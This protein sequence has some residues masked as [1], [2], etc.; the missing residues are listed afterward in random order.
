M[1]GPFDGK[2]G[3]SAISLMMRN[4]AKY[5][6]ESPGF[7][8]K[9]LLVEPGK[10]VSLS[11]DFDTK[12]IGDFKAKEEA[13]EELKK[14]VERLGVEQ[15]VLYAGDTYA[16]LVVLQALDAAGKDGTIK[17]VMTGVNPQGCD[18]HSFKA[19]SQE[20]LDHDYLWRAAMR[21]P[22]RGRIG[23]FNR[24]YYEEV[25]VARVHP[26]LL[27]QQH[28]PP[29]GKRESIWKRRYEEINS[30]ERYLVN[31]GIVVLKFFLN[32]SKSEQKSRFLKRI[33]EKEKNWK[34]SA[35][36][37]HERRF[38]DDYIEAFEEVF[39]R[40]ST[41]WAPW[42]IIPADHKWFT[43]LCVSEII[44]ATLRSLGLKYPTIGDQELV[45]LQKAKEELLD[46]K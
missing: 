5:L 14:S 21:L 28:L 40:T 41:D 45:E 25:L 4:L 7:D 19:P 2:F 16:L 31:N 3:R 24:S 23:I 12:Y 43:R 46:E 37:I 42:F 35:N 29:L 11:K 38:W 33:E 13:S 15:D 9:H 18:V 26:E 44:V 10:T 22:Q 36:D 34:F 1:P 32:V 17:H 6:P 39:H 30:F 8:L 27:A 20:E